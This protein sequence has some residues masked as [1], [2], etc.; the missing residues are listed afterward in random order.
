MSEDMPKTG[1]AASNSRATG[2]G[3][4][5]GAAGRGGDTAFKK[6]LDVVSGNRAAGGPPK[7]VVNTKRSQYSAI[8]LLMIRFRPGTKCER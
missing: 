4:K 3:A 2:G 1:A 6:S 5:T 7:T 8:K